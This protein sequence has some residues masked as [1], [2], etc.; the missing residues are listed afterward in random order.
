M[1]LY[2]ILRTGV[3][4]LNAQSNKLGTIADNIANTGTTGYKRSSTEFSA[5][6]IEPE[7]NDYNSGVVATDV[8]HDI[9]KQ[10]ALEFTPSPTDLAIQGDGFFVVRDANG[11]EKLTRAGSFEVDGRNGN[12]INAGG[13]T[14]MG[15]NTFEG[16]PPLE[17]NGFAGLEPIDTSIMNMDATPSREGV[18][19]A[20]LD[21]RADVVAGGAGDPLPS[22]NLAGSSFSSVSSMVVYD[23]LGNETTLDVYFTKTGTAPESYEMTVFD[24]A[25]RNTA[26]PTTNFPYGAGPLQS[27][28]LD[29][30][31]NGTFTGVG[32]PTVDPTVSDQIDAATPNAIDIPLDPTVAADT[33]IVTLDL[34]AT[35]QLAADFTPVDVQVDGNGASTVDTVRVTEDGRVYA[36]YENGSRAEWFR[37]PLADVPSPDMLKPTAGTVF[38]PTIESGDVLMSWPSE[39]GT[40]TIISGA[41]EQSN[42]DVADELTEMILAQRDYTA[43]SKSFQTGNELLEVLLNLKR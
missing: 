3:S 10:G 4:G 14:L 9:S 41:L 26:D 8:R 13:F 2:S 7:T 11:N 40:G 1:S 39:G 15:Y 27:I 18:F 16:E 5:L 12:L 30:D 20:N 33:Q 19:T 28:T 17:L 31:N 6:I 23:D 25:D 24:A 38:E 43:N 36:E 34:S 37:I 42:V 21:S 29:F 35:T 22:D 32:A